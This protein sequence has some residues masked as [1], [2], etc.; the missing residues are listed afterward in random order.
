MTINPQIFKSY[1]IRGV[2][3]TDLNEEIIKEITKAIY[4]FF[5]KDKP[6][7]QLSVVVGHDMRLSSPQLFEIAVNTLVEMGAK[8]ID[9]GLVSTPT[10]YFSVFNYKYDCGFQVTAS[11][12][13]KEWNGME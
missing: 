7:N 12:N 8:V 9:I 3:P 6:D 2:Y 1:D 4:T 13:P 11:H 5:K 10:F